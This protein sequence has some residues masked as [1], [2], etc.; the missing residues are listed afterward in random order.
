MGV[1]HDRRAPFPWK[2]SSAKNRNAKGNIC[3]QSQQYAT[4][5]GKNG[6]TKAPQREKGV[7]RVCYDIY[8]IYDK[9]TS[10]KPRTEVLMGHVN[11]HVHMPPSSL[12]TSIIL[13]RTAPIRPNLPRETIR[14]FYSFRDIAC[15]LSLRKEGKPPTFIPVIYVHS[16][17]YNQS[18]LL[19]P[20]CQ[21][22]SDRSVR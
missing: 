2:A 8:D 13:T 1:V 6:K 15:Q 17:Q 11:N 19:T 5:D 14:Q 16:F 3:N 7:L 21:E 10:L 4:R 18:P 20:I 12:K 9:E 22:T